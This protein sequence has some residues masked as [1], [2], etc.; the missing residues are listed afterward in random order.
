MGRVSGVHMV[1]SSQI[2]VSELISL[3]SFAAVLSNSC[4]I[5]V[6]AQLHAAE[7]DVGVNSLLILCT[8]SF[9]PRN[10]HTENLFV[11]VP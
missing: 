1:S 7:C 8:H 6:L 5:M 3:S 10:L 11:C 4:L 2:S 9:R